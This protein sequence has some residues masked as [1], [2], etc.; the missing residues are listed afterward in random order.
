VV[1]VNQEDKREETAATFGACPALGQNARDIAVPSE[2]ADGMSL[3][4]HA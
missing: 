1:I 2:V 3:L 4:A